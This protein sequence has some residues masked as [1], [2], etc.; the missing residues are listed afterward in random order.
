MQQIK[1]EK[2]ISEEIDGIRKLAEL[3]PP[4][5]ARTLMNRCDKILHTARKA[6]AIAEAPTGELFARP[7]NARYDA[8][9]SDDFANLASQRKKIWD[10]LLSG[11]KV[12]IELLDEWNQHM[13]FHSRIAEI[14]KD[15]EVKNLPYHLCDEWVYPGEGRSKYKKYWLIPKEDEPCSQSC[16]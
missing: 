12:S 9:D 16:S 4:G 7:V 6:Q 2:R 1:I 15:I 5:K 14:R 3:L 10:A 8:R 11:R 13:E